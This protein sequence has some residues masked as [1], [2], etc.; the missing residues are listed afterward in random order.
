MDKILIAGTFDI[1]H[2][3]HLNLLRQAKELGDFLIVVMARDENVLKT[4]GQKPFLNEDQRLDN[5]EK[6]GLVDKIVLGDLIDPY[7]VVK[8]E[9]PA[10]VA[11]GYDQQTFVNGL[12]GLRAN[13]RLNFRTERLE[14]FK[15]DVCKG[16]K[17]KQAVIDDQ[18]GF[19]LINK[20]E[21]WTSH[22]AVARL[23]SITGLKQIGHTGTLDPFATGLLICALGKA[24]KLVGLFDIL[25]K[26]YEA[27]VKLGVT[28]DTYDR[29]GEVKEQVPK[30]NISK[31][32]VEKVLKLF[33]G[34]QKQ[35]PPMYSAKK[36]GGK[37][38]Y[39]LAR[40]GK[41]IKRKA[42]QIE[43]YDLKLLD[44]ND[45]ILKIRVQCSTGTY[46]RSLASDLGQKLKTGA[47]LEELK[48]TAS[49]DFSLKEA[50]QIERLTKNNYS[51]FLIK[52]LEAIDRVNADY[53]R[54]AF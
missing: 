46:I 8:E 10:V 25:P 41:E 53:I 49:G 19:L 18:A 16:R 2:P 44:L 36:V 30:V 11:L 21:D 5:L 6:L 27:A 9:Q 51:E 42:S 26:T 43:I 22:D 52:P 34:K 13:S 17:I 32:Q 23:R 39:E 31:S 45:D 3:G 15:E 33:L 24:T 14:P 50:V 1:L 12:I 29:T 7:K 37:K 20:P 40:Q 38:L 48:R 28:S 47:I 54:R 35:L 4:K